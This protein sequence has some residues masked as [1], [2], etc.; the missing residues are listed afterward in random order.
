MGVAIHIVIEAQDDNGEWSAIT[1]DLWVPRDYELF[2]AIAFGEDGGGH[3]IPYPPRG[4]PEDHSLGT[5][6]RYFDPDKKSIRVM[7]RR[8]WTFEEESSPAK[9]RKWLVGVHKEVFKKYGLLPGDWVDASWLNLAE[10]EEAMDYGVVKREGLSTEFLKILSKMSRAAKKSGKD[11][12][13]M[14]FW[15]SP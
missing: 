9:I 11:K 5:R 13:R 6:L 15:F 12:V 10:L 14:V 8:T 4:I 3:G 2:S 7:N 1:D